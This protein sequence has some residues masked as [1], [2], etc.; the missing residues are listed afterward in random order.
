MLTELTADIINDRDKGMKYEA[1]VEKNR[2][3]ASDFFELHKF[4]YNMTKAAY[5]DM[6]KASKLEI[7]NAAF[8]S[9]MTD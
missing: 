2:K 3:A 1:R 4:M 7:T 5:T 9:C 6:K 8:H